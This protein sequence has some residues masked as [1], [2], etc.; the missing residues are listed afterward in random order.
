MT[1]LTLRDEFRAVCSLLARSAPLWLEYGVRG[2]AAEI[3]AREQAASELMALSGCTLEQ[4]QEVV[5]EY[6]S[7]EPYPDWGQFMERIVNMVRL[8]AIVDA[9][10]RGSNRP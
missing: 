3:A 5:N 7:T 6:V 1:D 8:E 10:E 9:H 2:A 4:A